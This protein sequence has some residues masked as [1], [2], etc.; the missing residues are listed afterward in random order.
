VLLQK[1]LKA[2]A[3]APLSCVY[4]WRIVKAAICVRQSEQTVHGVRTQPL[5]LIQVSLPVRASQIHT[6]P[7]VVVTSH[8]RSSL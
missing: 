6:A 8:M 2:T 7:V 5:Y 1:V 4:S 3:M